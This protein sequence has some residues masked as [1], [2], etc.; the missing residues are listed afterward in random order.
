V[1]LLIGHNTEE[2]N[3]YLVPQGQLVD[4]SPAQLQK[5]AAYAHPHP[6]ELLSIYSA[7]HPTAG[8]G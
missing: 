8:P 1:D 2:G 4:T 7:A 5:A 6:A 3:L